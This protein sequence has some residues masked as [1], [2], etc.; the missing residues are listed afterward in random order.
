MSLGSY[1]GAW[2]SFFFILLLHLVKENESLGSVRRE[3]EEKQ[4]VYEGWNSSA[5]RER[6]RGETVKPTGEGERTKQWDSHSS[7]VSWIS[8]W[9]CVYSSI[10]EK[11]SRGK[12]RRCFTSFKKG[13]EIQSSAAF[14]SL[15]YCD[16]IN[17]W[18]RSAQ[19]LNSSTRVKESSSSLP[20]LWR[21]RF[22]LSSF[23]APNEFLLELVR[24]MKGES[25]SSKRERTE[26]R[27]P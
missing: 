20:R 27:H 3:A 7:W 2:P 19:C 16:R 26:K 4:I 5:E 10:K 22:S 9:V 21:K 1:Q 24:R 11:R 13:E 18:R 12:W 15:V 14:L 6:G 8:S 25:N 23:K 17:R